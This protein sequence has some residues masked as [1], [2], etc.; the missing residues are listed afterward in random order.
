MVP[1]ITVVMLLAVDLGRVYFA[2]VNLTNVARIGANYAAQNPEAWEGTGNATVK[3]RYQQLMRNDATGIDCTLPATLP[4]PAF[5]ESTPFTYSLGSALSVELECRFQL[6][7]PFLFGLV[8]DGSGGLTVRTASSFNIRAGSVSG[9]AVGGNI[10]TPTPTIT[11][12]APPTPTPAPD[13]T[14]TATPDPSAGPTPTPTAAPPVVTFYGDPLSVDSYGGGPPGS[15]D[16]SLI[17]GIPGL[18]IAFWNTTAGGNCEWTVGDGNSSTSCGYLTQTYNTRGWYS[19]TLTVDGGSLTRTNYV[20]VGCKVPAFAGVRK[21]SA[22]VIWTNAGFNAGNFTTLPGSG[23][24]K[25]GYQS[26]AGGLL[27][28]PGGCSGA[29]IQVG[30]E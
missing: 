8:G 9:V 26:L 4:A 7:S 5:E 25:I 11:P 28:P 13:P 27:N 24:Y 15:T 21:N 23:N 6:V 30:P 18:N 19:V 2:V 17:V 29:T 10:P 3:S 12:T 1:V 22:L 20:L 16:E 14:P